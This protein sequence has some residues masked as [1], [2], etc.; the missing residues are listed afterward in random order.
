MNNTTPNIPSW[1]LDGSK[2]LDK[3]IVISDVNIN[4]PDGKIPLIKNSKIQFVYGRRYGL[5]GRNGSGKSTL[6]QELA[7]YN[8]QNAP[9][10]LR[11]VYVQQHDIKNQ[12]QNVIDY[13][14]ASDD[15][16]NFL[17]RE[18]ERILDKLENDNDAD[19]DEL[20]EKLDYITE[21][22]DNID[23]RKAQFNAKTILTGLGFT[24]EM[25][26]APINLLSGG[27]KQRVAL[28]CA[29]F[30]KPDLLVLDE[31]TNHL[32][33]PGLLWLQNYLKTIT[34]TLVLISHDREFLNDIVTDIVELDEQKL[35]YYRGNYNNFIKVRE[36]NFRARKKDW[37]VQTKKIA[38]LKQFISE[39]KKSDNVGTA[40]SVPTRQKMLDNELNNLIHEPIEVKPLT[41]KFINPKKLDHMLL[42]CNEMSFGY[43]KNS[44]LLKSVNLSL[45][46]DSKIGVYGLNGAGK[47]TL[48]KLI[49]GKLQPTKGICKINPKCQF[50]HFTQHHIDQLDLNAVALDYVQNQFPKA[51]VHELRGLLSRFGIDATKV[52]RKIGDLSGG[53]RSRIAFAILAYEE[54]HLIIFDEPTN[55]LDLETIESLVA[56]VNDY[57]GA[58]IVVSHDQYFLSSTAKEFWAINKNSDVEIFY[59]SDEAREFAYPN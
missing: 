36:D 53:E 16:K 55:H 19:F 39:A 41:F 23:S 18:N 48:L 7:S 38:D 5:I 10:H 45:E 24:N 47:S 22:L 59:N 56:A 46:L 51:K 57:I 25:Q 50:V 34:H 28:A 26:N 1:I 33:F 6:L 29:L 11:I 13:V 21:R 27:W 42:E 9:Q 3:N 30:V 44:E 35:T 8:L 49:T 58:V 32:D 40:N 43:E 2:Q 12:D 37:E 17:E 20:N 52:F 31:P 15:E 54:P 14:L 4:T